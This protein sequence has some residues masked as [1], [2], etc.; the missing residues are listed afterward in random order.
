MPFS[1]MVI[2]EAAPWAGTNNVDRYWSLLK[3]NPV[4]VLVALTA[5]AGANTVHAPVPVASTAIA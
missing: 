2:F 4:P 3:G 5:I 1:S